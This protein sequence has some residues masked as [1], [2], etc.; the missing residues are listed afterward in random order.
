VIIDRT[1]R[2]WAI[3][4]AVILVAAALLY[5]PYASSQA[6]KGGSWPG[7]AYGSA[8][9]AMMLGA[10]LLGA[11]KKVPVWRLGRAHTWMRSHVW[12]GLMSLPIILF[13]AG[14]AVGGG[15]TS[16]LMCLLVV[17]VGSG[18]LG[19]WLQHRVPA[20]MLR[21]LPMETIYDQIDHVRA[22]LLTEADGLVADAC[23]KL[24]LE[25]LTPGASP[26]GA[27]RAAAHATAAALATIDRIDADESAPLREFY[28]GAVRPFVKRP[29]RAHPLADRAH[30]TMQFATVRGLVPARFHGV[31]EDLEHICEEQRQ[32]MQQS[33]M[34]T[35]LH[36]WL[37]VHVPLSLALLVLAVVHIVMALRY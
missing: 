9:F 21:D 17:V 18:L 19:T 24:E 33:S 37:L 5:I 31:V 10:G 15:L 29:Q 36:G 12:L 4:S 3:S 20:R 30:A 32:L 34:H 35:L 28:M 7:L 16:V 2:W 22:Q 27:A 13:H 1:H 8:G 14:F 11:R 6:P 25:I 23:G 26:G